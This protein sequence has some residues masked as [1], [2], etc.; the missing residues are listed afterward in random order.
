MKILLRCWNDLFEAISKNP[1]L[2]FRSI[3]IDSARRIFRNLY[4]SMLEISYLPIIAFLP[5]LSRVFLDRGGGGGIA[6]VKVTPRRSL[7]CVCAIGKWLWRSFTLEHA[8]LTLL[9]PDYYSRPLSSKTSFPSIS[10]SFSRR[11]SPS[12][13]LRA[14]NRFIHFR[15][16]F[17]NFLK[18]IHIREPTRK[19]K[20]WE[21]SKGKGIPSRDDGNRA[22][23]FSG[24][25][26]GERTSTG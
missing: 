10:I 22:H 21:D 19:N 6:R 7:S 2:Y 20:E 13:P 9:S 17:D 15:R 1:Q 4:F 12:P 23:N 3:S 24:R 5:K 11:N 25:G 8:L 16:T 18:K 14:R 26:R